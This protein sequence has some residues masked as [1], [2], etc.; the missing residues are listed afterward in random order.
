MIGALNRYVSKKD[1]IGFQPMKANFGL[2]PSLS[3]KVKPKR[4]RHQAYSDR[5]LK[6]LD[7]FINQHGA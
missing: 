1:I 5:A 6:D 2:L 7:H 3:E 4:A